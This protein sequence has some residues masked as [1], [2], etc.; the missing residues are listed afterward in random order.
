MDTVQE[1]VDRQAPAAIPASDDK[2]RWRPLTCIVFRF[3]LIY[4]TLYN[5]PFPLGT[6]P[7]TDKAADKYFVIW[8]AIVP[9]VGNHLLHLSHRITV[10]ANGSGDT[11]Y[12]Y[13]LVLCYL[14]LAAAAT[15]GW[16]MLDR[17]RTHY[18]S[19][20][21][22]LRLYVR[23][24]LGS[25][26]IAYGAFKVIQSQFP[27]PALSRLIETYGESSPMGLLWTSMGASHLYNVFAGLTEMS[28]GVLLFVPCLT[29]LGALILAGALS[30]VFMLNMSYDVPVKLYSFHLLLMAIF[31]IAPDVRRLANFLVLNRKVEPAADE[32]L[33]KR[34]A[35]NRGALAL[36]LVFGAVFVGAFLY[37][38][39]EQTRQYGALA[40]KSPLYGIWSVDDFVL[41]GTVRPPLTTDDL[42]WQR[43][44]FEQSEV[45]TVQPMHGSD[46]YFRLKM[47]AAHETFSLGKFGENNKNWTADF[48]FTRL[49]PDR[50]T[51]EG[52]LDGKP[53]QVKLERADTKFLLTTRGFH[54]INEYPFNR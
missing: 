28:G 13:V 26:M 36:Q 44:I 40:L 10:F 42:R 39:H 29:T 14:L 24:C 2:R 30:N 8:H 48:V 43:L 46:A 51:L 17:S 21:K 1:E 38:S 49:Q 52:K 23:F 3:V 41:D 11:T 12:D 18:C 7:H 53:V 4:L 47:D 19:L 25:T 20:H 5:L 35:L 54:W 22:W 27:A 15:L 34:Q 45:L 37:Q 32:P 31:L 16:S 6:L 50:L 33:F 9:W